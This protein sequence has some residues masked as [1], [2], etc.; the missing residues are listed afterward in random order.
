VDESKTKRTA[1]AMD[2]A[3]DL[4]SIAILTLLMFCDSET[5]HAIIERAA[6]IHLTALKPRFDTP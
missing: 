1:S 6:S 4:V 5:H 2:S 3:T